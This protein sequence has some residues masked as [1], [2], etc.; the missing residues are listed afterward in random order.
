VRTLGEKAAAMAAVECAARAVSCAHASR[1]VGELRPPCAAARSKLV[2]SAEADVAAR[3]E[4]LARLRAE[5]KDRRSERG[6]LDVRGAGS[7]KGQA[8]VPV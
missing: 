8:R 3:A 1:A 5:V 4:A 6:K 7:S 2:K